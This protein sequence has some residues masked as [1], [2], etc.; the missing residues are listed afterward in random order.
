MNKLPFSVDRKVKVKVTKSTNE[1]LRPNPDL[2]DEVDESL[3]RLAK[4]I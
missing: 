3:L 2:E 1:S 4:L